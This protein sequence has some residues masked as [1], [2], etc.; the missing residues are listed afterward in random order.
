MRVKTKFNDDVD[1][2][3]AS[4]GYVTL[5]KD[6][7]SMKVRVIKIQLPS[8][9][10]E[11]LLTNLSHKTA[12]TEDFKDLYFLRWKVE[13][14]YNILKNK[15]E[16]ENFSSRTIDGIKQD[17]YVALYQVNALAALSHDAQSKADERREGKENK[18]EYQI[19]R[20][21]AIGI[22]KSHFIQ[23]ILGKSGKKQQASLRK[24]VEF[25]SRE[26][27]PIRPNRSNTRNPSPR[28]S[29]FHHNQKSTA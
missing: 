5:K 29:K 20:N 23:S 21:E 12:T 26:V 14:H 10:I 2:Q 15:L 1:L 25:S 11:T 22:F 8:G 18:Y 19:N 24:M 9:E 27:V 16:L 28:R 6:G 3:T 7:Q 17:F 13:C 4:D